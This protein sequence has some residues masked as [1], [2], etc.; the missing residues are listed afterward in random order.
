MT[1]RGCG[2]R[3]GFE[4]SPCSILR[5]GLGALEHS[6]FPLVGNGR[7]N[8]T[9]F[10][11]FPACGYRGICHRPVWPC[12]TRSSVSSDLASAAFIG[13]WHCGDMSVLGSAVR[14]P[15]WV[16]VRRVD[17]VGCPRS[18]TSV[19]GWSADVVYFLGRDPFGA[20]GSAPH[21][22]MLDVSI[23]LTG[24]LLGSAREPGLPGPSFG[25][26]AGGQVLTAVFNGIRPRSLSAGGSSVCTI[27]GW[28]F[29]GPMSSSGQCCRSPFVV[30]DSC[31]SLINRSKTT[32]V[33]RGYWNHIW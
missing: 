14:Y 12:A 28:E 17:V 13:G 10:R 7:W 25:E 15:L 23:S 18:V 32:G 8:R 33:D 29:L 5:S 16:C 19:V 2:S 6:S 20:S 9:A 24:P 26:G 3:N 11:P 21:V 27:F 30:V 31:G 1:L 22:H 4:G